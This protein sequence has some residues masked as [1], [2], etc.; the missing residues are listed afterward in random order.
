MVLLWEQD[1]Q[2]AGKL[3]QT[4]FLQS[5]TL[6]PMLKRLESLGYLRRSR[7]LAD[8]R[9]VRCKDGKTNEFDGAEHH[10][11]RP[12]ADGSVMSGS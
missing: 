8:Q 6:T 4:L 11:G 7:D 2:T 9:R 3:G 1:G 10:P 12:E 5:N